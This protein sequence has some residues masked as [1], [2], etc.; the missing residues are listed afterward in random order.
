MR[1]LVTGASG[2]IGS[3][4]APVLASA[5]HTV[6]ALARDPARV[7]CEGIDE[8][9]T[10]DALTGAGLDAAAA[11]ADVV[12]YLIHSMEP[13]PP[14]AGSFPERERTSAANVVAAC[15]RAG[16]RRIVYL[17]GLVPQGR[18]PS[19]HLS[20]RMA[21]RGCAARRG[22]GGRGAARVDRHQRG[23]AI[24]PLSRAARRAH[25]GP[26]AAVVA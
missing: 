21:R 1:I 6:R 5:G 13:A 2:A 19:V 26:A 7:R 8:I 12:Y 10:G 11:G 9:V 22:A 25:P 15:R 16:V 23:L 24:V 18:A 17:G 20:S 14:G 4:L 3:A